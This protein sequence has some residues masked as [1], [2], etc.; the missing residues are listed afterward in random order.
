MPK[1]LN[2]D[3][4]SAMDHIFLIETNFEEKKFK[5][6]RCLCRISQENSQAKVLGNSDY[7]FSK[8]KIFQI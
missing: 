4:G 6:E 3:T 8:W 2:A 1:H 7:S 5:E